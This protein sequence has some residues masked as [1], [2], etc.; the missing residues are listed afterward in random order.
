MAVSTAQLA[1]HE[2]HCGHVDPWV[3]GLVVQANEIIRRG[4]AQPGAEPALRAILDRLM[5]YDGVGF[6][7]RWR[8][9]RA[10]I[11]GIKR[12]L[13]EGMY[14]ALGA[15]GSFGRDPIWKKAHHCTLSVIC[16]PEP[17]AVHG[18]PDFPPRDA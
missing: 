11:A 8:G 12:G 1:A 3:A 10:L 15:T 7:R 2:A 18:M 14:V 13:G 4:V 5:I 17:F 16:L 6:F 9:K